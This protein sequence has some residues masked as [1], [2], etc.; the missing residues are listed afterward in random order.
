MLPA[1]AIQ[2]INN[3]ATAYADCASTG[4]YGTSDTIN[5]PAGAYTATT[6]CKFQHRKI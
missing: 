6:G 5:I 4:G 2:N 3:A 1:W